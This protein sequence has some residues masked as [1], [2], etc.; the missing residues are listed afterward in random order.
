MADA[1][2]AGIRLLVLG[3]GPGGY[4]AAFLGAELGLDVTL[5][6][7]GER[8]VFFA[9]IDNFGDWRNIAVHRID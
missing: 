1:G 7:E 2:T 8:T 9:D 3:G 5:V 4:A 6:D